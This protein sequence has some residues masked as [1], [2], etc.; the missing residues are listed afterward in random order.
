MPS[1]YKTLNQ[2]EFFLPPLLEIIY[3]YF[4]VVKKK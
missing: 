4:V 2:N 3:G 1:S